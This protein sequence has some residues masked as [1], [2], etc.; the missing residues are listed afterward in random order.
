[1]VLGLRIDGATRCS[2]EL[3]EEETRRLCAGRRVRAL[4]RRHHRGDERATS[5]LLRRDAARRDSS[6]STA[7]WSD[8]LR[9]RILREIEAFVGDA[10]QHDDMTMILLKVD[11]PASRRRGSRSDVVA[12]LMTDLVVIFRTPSPIEADVVRGLL[13]AHGIAA[14]VSSRHVADAVSA[15]A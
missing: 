14:I 8:E 11:A 1:M 15:R 6:R 4:H 5:D 7:I 3:L 2:S 9:E 10:P 12:P 13:E